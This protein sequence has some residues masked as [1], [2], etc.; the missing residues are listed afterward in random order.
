MKRNG[1]KVKKE[2]QKGMRKEGMKANF[3]YFRNY[4]K[5]YE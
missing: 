4:E 1:R 5:C 3:F 2:R